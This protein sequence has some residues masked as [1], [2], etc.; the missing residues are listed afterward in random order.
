MLKIEDLIATAPLIMTEGAVV[1]RLRREFK[2]ELDPYLVHSGFIY[3]SSNRE[4]LRGIYKGYIDIVYKRELPILIFTPT[5]RA[6]EE[7][8]VQAGFNNI[9]INGDCVRFLSQI[10]DEYGNFAK[11]IYI[12]GI[13]GCKNDAYK[14]QESLET[15]EA[16]RFHRFQAEALS[17][18]GVDFLYGATL[19]AYVEALGL[20]KAMAKTKKPYILSFVIRNDGKLLDG[21]SLHEAFVGI[22]SSVNPKPL[23][24]MVN[25][26]H[27]SVLERSLQ[28]NWNSNII[29]KQRLLGIQSNTSS[30]SPEELDNSSS[31]ESDDFESLIDTMVALHFEYGLKV[32]G[33]CCGTNNKHIEKMVEGFC[34]G[35]Q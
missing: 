19:P 15:D 7:R 11:K 24:Y 22:D 4:I 32:M 1:E 12:G 28:E 33:G 30:K 20:A 16:E 27:P 10:R 31:V 29:V 2:V 6:N 9:D 8:L 18:A 14:A 17:N 21:T 13:M 34:K 3:N 25:C 5:R 23:G 35:K 26:I